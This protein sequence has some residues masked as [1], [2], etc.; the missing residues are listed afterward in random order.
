MESNEIDNRFR[1]LMYKRGLQTDIIRLRKD[2]IDHLRRIYYALDF[3]GI[4]QLRSSFAAR[5][6][7]RGYLR[8]AAC[9][10]RG[11]PWGY[12]ERARRL[13]G[14]TLEKDVLPVEALALLEEGSSHAVRME[15][16][17]GEKPHVVVLGDPARASP[18]C[19]STWPCAWPPRRR[20]PCPS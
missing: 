18:P 4:Q 8:A 19:S 17:L 9:T 13:A 15:E 20:R 3:R 12:W 10:S 1:L 16:A 11:P 2:Y 5:A 7:A 6:A 14:R